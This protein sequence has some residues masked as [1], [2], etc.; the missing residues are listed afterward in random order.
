MEID[1]E[2]LDV[3]FPLQ[4]QFVFGDLGL[5]FCGS[6]GESY[7]DRYGTLSDAEINQAIEAMDAAGG[8]ADQLVSRIYNQQQEGSCVANA[9]SQAHEIIQAKQ[10]GIER[11]VHLSAISLYKRIG[12]SPS[13]G[14]M[15]SDG[16]A[17]MKSRGILPLDNEANRAKFGGIVMPNTGFHTRYPDGWETVAK[18]FAGL[19]AT[20]IR[21]VAGIFTALCNQ[22]PVVVGRQGHS[23]CYTRPM[24]KGNKR[25]VKYAN[26]WGNWGDGG[27]GYDSESQIKQSAG[28]AFAL[29]SVTVPSA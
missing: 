18:Q 10:F 20:I 19:E 21:S 5:P 27:F 9:T 28:W 11:V 29:R 15:V 22:D 12:R 16:W 7:E 3:D 14:A 23:I 13:S 1:P 6:Y 26:S 25:V 8:G 17:E 4:P 2:F 24:R